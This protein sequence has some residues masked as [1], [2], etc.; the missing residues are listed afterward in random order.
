MT[1]PSEH[2]EAVDTLQAEGQARLRA[3]E[4]NVENANSVTAVNG[5]LVGWHRARAD[6]R[7][8][9]GSAIRV[10]AVLAVAWSV[11]AMVHWG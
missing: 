3:M 6:V 8:A 1:M 9:F 2:Q 10:G 5:A 4:A 11:W 7:N